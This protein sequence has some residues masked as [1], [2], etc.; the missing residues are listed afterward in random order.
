MN[1]LVGTIFL[2][3]SLLNLNPLLT[4]KHFGDPTNSKMET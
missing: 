4:M 2:L 3:F 1:A